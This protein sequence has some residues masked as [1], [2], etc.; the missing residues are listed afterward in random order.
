MTGN[1]DEARV[2]RLVANKCGLPPRAVRVCVCASLPRLSNGKPDYEAMR[3]M[4][5]AT[6]Q[7]PPAPASTGPATGRKTRSAPRVGADDL[8]RIYAEVLDRTDVTP[9]STF[10]SLGGDSLSYVEMSVRAEAALGHLPQQWHTTRI[11]DFSPRPTPRPTRIE[12]SIALRAISIVLIV[13]THAQ[14]FAIAGG[15][16]LLLGIAGFNLARFHLTDAPRQERVR[17]IL[18]SLRRIVIP[19]RGLDRTGLSAH[20]RLH[21]APR[22]PTALSRRAC[23]RTQPLLVYR[24][25]HLHLAGARALLAVPQVDRL[26][27]RYPFALPLGLMLLGLATRYQLVPGGASAYTGGGV[28]ARRTRLGDGKSD[29]GV[30]SSAGDIRGRRHHP[31]VLRQRLPRSRRDHWTRPAGLG[32]RACPASGRSTGWPACSPAR[33]SSST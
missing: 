28:L 8:C 3:A 24:G 29:R 5:S 4:R 15:A 25:T 17:A 10:V 20:R 12:T 27:R 19:K 32:P 18:R 30:A 31:G 16:H 26:E 6:T 22:C 7:R 14:L 11:H 33:R 13:G 21:A 23:G 9:Q 1:H 2:R